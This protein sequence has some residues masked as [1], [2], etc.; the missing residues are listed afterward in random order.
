MRFITF[1]GAAG[2][3]LA[4]L[5]AVEAQQP[6]RRDGDLKEG[7]LAPDFTLQD[8]EGKNPVKLSELKGKPVVL[9]FGSCT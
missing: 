7:G 9:L 2:L 6:Q 1:G 5:C 3:L 8:A 4:A